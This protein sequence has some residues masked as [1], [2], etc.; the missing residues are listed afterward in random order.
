M[1]IE[2]EIDIG[3]GSWAPD[4]GIIEKI[5]EAFNLKHMHENKDVLDNIKKVESE[6]L[7]DSDNPVSS[8]AV[9]AEFKKKMTE[10]D[11]DKKLEKI[12]TH[13]NKDVLDGLSADGESL[14]FNGKSFGGG[15]E[16]DLELLPAQIV[17]S[18]LSKANVT[19]VFGT[20]EEISADGSYEDFFFATGMNTFLVCVPSE[21]GKLIYMNGDTYEFTEE[22]NVN[23]GN[24]IIFWF[25]NEMQ[26]SNTAK[27]GE[28]LRQLL[29]DGIESV[30]SES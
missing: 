17:A 26:L 20:P 22:M 9:H 5:N 3:S 24:L 4:K 25:N 18:L 23:K 28:S 8:K 27:G 29:V 12:H 14:M 7:N 10:E 11:V 21:S 30:T 13:K 2:L 1:K 16:I 6:V 15:A 19:T